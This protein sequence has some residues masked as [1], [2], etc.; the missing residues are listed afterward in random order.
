MIRVNLLPPEHR[1][2]QGTPLGH[3]VTIL[4]SILLA[5]GAAGLWGWT[6]FVQLPGARDLQ[7][8][9]QSELDAKQPLVKRSKDLAA[10]LTAYRDRR[11]AIQTINRSRVLWS[12]KLDQFFDIVAHEQA[13]Y[14]AWLTDVDVPN[15]TT[16]A[17][18]RG[19]RAGAKAA[20]GGK[21][22]FSAK[23]AMQNVNDAPAQGSLFYM[24][25]TGEGSGSPSEFFQDFLEITNPSANI[26]DDGRSTTKER[27]DPPVVA[28]CLYE[29]R[30]RA[31]EVKPQSRVPVPPGRSPASAGAQPK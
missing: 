24:R 18:A 7:S 9:R 5:L 30:L 11:L 17:V 22:R 8:M 26:E 29:L 25:I 4:A 16:S 10:E 19:G 28:A 23:L 2:A 27:L 1:P 15:Q 14:Q 6:H 31:R 13:G 20:D 3:F 12:Q 21:L